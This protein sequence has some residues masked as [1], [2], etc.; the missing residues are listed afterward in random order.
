MV[1]IQDSQSWHRGSIPLSTTRQRKTGLEKFRLFVLNATMQ[2]EMQ[3]RTRML[4]GDEAVRALGNSRVA[5]FG[6]GGV[7]GHAVEALARSGVGQLDLFDSDCVN[8]SNLNR[9]II[10]LRSTI[11]QPKVDA[12]AARIRDINPDCVVHK[13]NIFYLPE[14]ADGVDLSAY[15]CVLDCV[16]TI[17]AKVELAKRCQAAGTP[18]ISSMGTA[19]KMDPTAFKVT[20]IFKTKMDP[21]AK[22]LRKKLKECGVRKLKVV[23]SEETPM[24]PH[25]ATTDGTETGGERPKGNCTRPKPGLGS[26]SFVPACAG[27][28]MAGEAIKGIIGF[29]TGSKPQQK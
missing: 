15:D 26:V 9:Q 2:D 29:A 23:Y 3:S 13:H 4:I 7:G 11:G 18:I 6:I 10:A 19:N 21:I 25:P 22:I 1:R 17:A 8:T 20:D 28:I 14:T 16:D 5:V 24:Q 27:L 12:A